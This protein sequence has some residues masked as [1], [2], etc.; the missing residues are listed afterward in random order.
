MGFTIAIVIAGIIVLILVHEAGH[1][2]AAKQMNVDVEE[3]GFGFPPRIAGWKKGRT[4]YSIN[5]LP[6]GGFVRLFGE[7][8]AA[9]QG[10]PRQG[11]GVNP[12]AFGAQAWW[13][14][15]A[16]IAAGVGMNCVAAWMFLSL[17]FFVGARAGILVT[18]VVPDSPAAS[19]GIRDG[20]FILG[21]ENG[22]ALV[23]AMATADGQVIELRVL[24]GGSV[25]SLALAPDPHP[26]AGRGAL[27]ISFVET[28]FERVGPIAAVWHGFTE[29]IRG[30]GAIVVGIGGALVALITD[31]EAS[32]V[33]GPVGIIEIARQAGMLGGG[34]LLHLIGLISLNLA[35]INAIPFPALDGG[36][37]LFILIERIKGSPLPARAERWVNGAGF[38]LLLL[39]MV[40]ITVKDVV[41]AL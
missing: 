15:L 4:L 33:V 17:T 32:G 14:R 5:A 24:R 41:N 8:D 34:Y 19:A 9:R 7:E 21:Y 2:I 11:R 18:D 3:F 26:P 13:K 27:G 1:F 29:T 20:D 10:E 23:S 25:E 36:R 16:I 22:A 30:F 12:H 35:V 28:G 38:A 39:L 37:A 6:F 31:R 40:M